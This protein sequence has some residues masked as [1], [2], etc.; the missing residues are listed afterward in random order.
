MQPDE[1][2]AGYR[3]VRTLGSGRTG[4][5]YE[6]EYLEDGS[7]VALH[8][9][10]PDRGGPAPEQFIASMRTVSELSHPSIAT[11]SRFGVEGDLASGG[12]PWCAT[13][14]V[15]GP[16]L[17]HAGGLSPAELSRV[18]GDVAAA[19][20]AAHAQGVLHRAVT[21]S[22]V[23]VTRGEDGAIAR[24]VV[25]DFG[26]AGADSGPEA[27]SF[28][29]PEL[30]QGGMPSPA[31]DQY[32]LAV[33]VFACLTGRLPFEAPTSA[34]LMMAQLS[35]PVP[36]VGDPAVDAVLA[37]A[38][39]KDPRARFVS[40]G[41]FAGALKGALAVSDPAAQRSVS[42]SK[43]VPAPH[44]PVS[45]VVSPVPPARSSSRRKWLWPSR[46]AWWHCL[47]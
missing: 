41:E 47:R 43:A 31:S 42:L 30:L 17:A 19:L 5:M 34:G 20:D 25:T 27:L 32:S 45:P 40:C 46:L 29:A 2:F 26:V 15:D 24:V 16:D 8:V 11:I 14:F 6:A 1:E 9:I 13:E 4:T 38:L 22:N 37:R 3:V 33:L 23:I 35:A 28:A 36:S 44:V 18:V 12:V 39:A 7:R 10:E 21:P